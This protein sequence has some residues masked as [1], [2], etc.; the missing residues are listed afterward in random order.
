MNMCKGG[1]STKEVSL[2]A[3]NYP[4]NPFFR[5]LQSSFPCGPCSFVSTYWPAE[6]AG[7]VQRGSGHQGGVGRGWQTEIKHKNS[8]QSSEKECG[9]FSVK[10]KQ[11]GWRKNRNDIFLKVS[12]LPWRGCTV[13]SKRKARLPRTV[14]DKSLPFFCLK[15]SFTT[16]ICNRID[17]TCHSNWSPS[18]KHV[19]NIASIHK[20]YIIIQ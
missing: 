11:G 19:H 2:D 18:L 17:S 15:P 7:H 20:W 5:G 14:A 8:S 13:W 3:V 9:L 6:E 12:L 16:H 4:F 1:D 10:A